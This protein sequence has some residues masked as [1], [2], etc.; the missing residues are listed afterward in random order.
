[1]SRS[2]KWIRPVKR[3]AVYTRDNWT[4]VYCQTPPAQQIHKLSI[5]H[6]L[7]E[8]LGGS[9]VD[10]NLVTACVPCNSAKKAQR[11]E[12]FVQDPERCAAIRKQA[13]RR[14]T[15]LIQRFHMEALVE[16]EVKR[17]CAELGV[18]YQPPAPPQDASIVASMED[19]PP[20]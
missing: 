17:R 16:A 2:S 20:F 8:A 12:E 1:M 18:P 19:A 6:L 10:H 9:N 13:K 14:L 11:L 15:K 7:P 4:C 5:D 3:R